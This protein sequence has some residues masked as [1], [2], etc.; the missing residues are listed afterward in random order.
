MEP[1]ETSGKSGDDSGDA[2]RDAPVKEQK[3]VGKPKPVQKV[4]GTKQTVT[5][6]FK[7]D[8]KF[9]LHV[10]RETMVFLGREAREIPREWLDHRDFRQVQKYFVVKGV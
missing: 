8:R 2:G 10:G 6:V 5:V 9:D 4:V 3:K 7:Q 1:E